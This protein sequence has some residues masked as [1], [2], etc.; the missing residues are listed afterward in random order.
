MR[1]QPKGSHQSCF[2]ACF[3]PISCSRKESCSFT[4]RISA[5][6]LVSWRMR[7][8]VRPPRLLSGCATGAPA[9]LTSSS[10]KNWLNGIGKG[11]KGLASRCAGQSRYGDGQDPDRPCRAEGRREDLCLVHHRTVNPLCHRANDRLRRNHARCHHAFEELLG[12]A[13]GAHQAADPRQFPGAI[14]LPR[15]SSQQMQ[16]R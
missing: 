1:Q 10:L 6:R 9:I 12:S 15:L 13:A 8:S 5:E 7:S 4:L 3:N 14:A 11:R 2:P 16:V